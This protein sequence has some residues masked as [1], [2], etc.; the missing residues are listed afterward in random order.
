MTRIR[1]K[2]GTEEKGKIKRDCRRKR[3]ARD[4]EKKRKKKKEDG[5]KNSQFSVR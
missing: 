2:R 5:Y 4:Q 1:K 3:T